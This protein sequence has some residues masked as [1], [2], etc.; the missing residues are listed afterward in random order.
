MRTFVMIA[1]LVVCFL[2][3]PSQ[4][5]SSQTRTQEIAASFNKQKHAVKEKNGV[6]TEKYKE[7]SSESVV[8]PNMTDYSGVYEV[9]DLG[10]AITI[11]VTS[12]GRV[13]ASGSENG[14]SFRFDNAR[15][16]GALLSATKIYHDGTAEKFEGV[17][18]TR[19]VPGMAA[20]RHR[21]KVR[22]G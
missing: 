10:Y 12:D 22:Y 13:Q 7:V 1:L 9:S 3:A 21:T 2:N 6:R 18:M 17:F 11:Q 14:R 19:T 5:S 8:K 4:Q 15:I 16:E 20:V